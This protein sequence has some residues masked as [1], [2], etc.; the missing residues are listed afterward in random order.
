[1]SAP[2]HQLLGVTMLRQRQ[3]LARKIPAT[4]PVHLHSLPPHT[5]KQTCTFLR[6]ESG[7]PLPQHGPLRA[8]GGRS[9]PT[10]GARGTVWGL[11]TENS[12]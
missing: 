11:R 2:P 8:G 6:Q 4:T 12:E 9:A 1:M 5:P 7:P 10:R 3:G